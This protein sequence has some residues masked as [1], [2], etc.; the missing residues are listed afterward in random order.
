[1]TYVIKK[2][3]EIGFEIVRLE[4]DNHKSNV[5]A[6]GIICKGAAT[7]I[8]P[9]PSDESRRIFLAFDQSHI[10]TNVRSQFLE[11]D[12]GGNKQITATPLKKLYKMQRG[13]TVKPVRFLMRRHLYPSN[14]EKMSVKTAV[15]IFSPPVT[16]AL[17]YMK[18]QAGSHM[19]C[20]VRVSGPNGRIQAG[21][22]PVVRPH[23]C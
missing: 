13:S 10:I 22:A 5:A 21:N 8:A 20:G 6:M 19:R 15:Q 1:M 7:A 11:K 3:E 2:T 18:S 12:M 16:A 4:T 9:H 17:E 14:I 23:G